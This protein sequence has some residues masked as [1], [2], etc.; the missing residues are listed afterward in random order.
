VS[1]SAKVVLIGLYFIP[2]IVAGQRH[3]PQRM[4]IETLNLFLG[5]TF[6]GWVIALV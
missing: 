3:H 5:W 4:A 6:V 1:K 2:S